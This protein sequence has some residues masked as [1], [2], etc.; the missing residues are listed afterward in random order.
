MPD[1]IDQLILHEG[2]IPYAYPDSL[3]YLTIGVGRLIDSRKGGGLRAEE[4][5]FLLDND[6]NE[7]S[8]SLNESLPWWRDLSDVRRRVL[9]DMAFNLGVDG[10]LKFH[11]TLAAVK[12]R[13]YERAA[14]GMLTSL[15]AR[16]VKGRAIRL[17]E[18]MRSGEDYA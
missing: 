4:I 10:L 5:R 3:G 15:W 8:R 6:I 18:M 2:E 1:I 17:A 16:Q 7:I 12:A 9:I 14:E 13:E 11:D